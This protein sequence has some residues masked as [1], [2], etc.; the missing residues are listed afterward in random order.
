MQSRFT[1][2]MLLFICLFTLPLAIDA[3]TDNDFPPLTE[4]FAGKGRLNGITFNYPEGWHTVNGI[5][6]NRLISFNIVSSVPIGLRNGIDPGEEAVVMAIAGGRIDR[7]GKIETAASAEDVLIAFLEQ[8]G[9]NDNFGGGQSDGR[10]FEQ[11]YTEFSV[12][13]YAAVKLVFTEIES[14]APM[15]TPQP[16]DEPIDGDFVAYA[17]LLDDNQFMVMLMLTSELTFAEVEPLINDML[18]TLDYSE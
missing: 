15:P 12:N 3:Q 11:V 7:W 1:A 6:V 2:L 5:P 10:E 18:D 13:G 8:V 17:L 14:D 9:D 16:D 4:T